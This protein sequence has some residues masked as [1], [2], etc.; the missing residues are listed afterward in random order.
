[1]LE[2]LG[3]R[4]RWLRTA[5]AV[6]QRVS[7]I[8]GGPMASS[9]T[10]AGFLSLFPLL[11]VG[12]AVLGFVSANRTDFAQSVV[13]QFG[14]T[15]DAAR[16]VVDAIAEA[17]QS[18]RA[19]SIVGLVGL[20]WAGLGVVG[21]LEQAFDATWQV[22]GRGWKAKLID[23]VWLVGAFGLF[24][25]TSALG[26][27]AAWLPGPAVVP[28]VAFGLVLDAVLLLWMFRALT[29]VAVAWTDHLPGAIVGAVGVEIL[30]L[31]GTIYVPRAASSASALYGSIGVVFAI[32]AWLALF[33]RL[34][35]YASALNVVRHEERYGT[36]T[37]EVRAPRIAGR[38]PV[39]ANRG[40]AVLDPDGE[41]AE[42]EAHPA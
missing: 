21:T 40:G 25:A 24:L 29:N 42:H 17:E 8:G 16:Q 32:L 38:V 9:I 34:V 26:P 2:R 23:L 15:G 3:R 10:L 37:V 13:D 33:A 18:R 6:H 5:L 41:R 36:V 1:V 35:V 30:K 19:A 22:T 7:D 4:F 12:V 28:A 27:V 31:V 11:L 39:E 14:L 20:L